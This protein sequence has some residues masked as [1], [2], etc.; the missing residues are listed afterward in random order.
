MRP[1]L[2]FI[3]PLNNLNISIAT[4]KQFTPIYVQIQVSDSHP[5]QS[6]L[7]KN[8]EILILNFYF[9]P[10]INLIFAVLL[11]WLDLKLKF[12]GYRILNRCLSYNSQTQVASTVFSKRQFFYLPAGYRIVLVGALSMQNY[13]FGLTYES[14]LSQK[15]L[16]LN[17]RKFTNS[18]LWLDLKFIINMTLYGLPFGFDKIIRFDIINVATIGFLTKKQQT[19]RI[20][21]FQKFDSHETSF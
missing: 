2:I 20:D 21:F 10:I 4:Y 18:T 9:D 14:I 15:Q 5:Y 7:V 13:C 3:R 16:T 19:L 12:S 17:H 6:H 8:W 1:I 11:S